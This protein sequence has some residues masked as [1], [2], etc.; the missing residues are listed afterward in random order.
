MKLYAWI[1]ED[2]FG[3][4]EVGL[5][6]AHV[7]AGFIPLVSLHREKIDRPAIRDQLSG[8]AR[9]YGKTIRLAEFTLSAE[10]LVTLRPDGGEDESHD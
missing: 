6:Q 8:Q 2:E 5:K 4:G 3:S 7:P 1:G 10:A 9:L